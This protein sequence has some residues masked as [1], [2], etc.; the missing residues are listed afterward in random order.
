MTAYVLCFAALLLFA[1]GLVH[2][3]LGEYRL[4]SPL[5]AE[6][7]RAGLL[8]KS[9][10]ARQVLRF[11]WHLTTVGMWGFAALLAAY[12]LLPKD[13]H[14]DAALTIIAIVCALS[15]LMTFAAS[16]GRHL[17]WPVFL[18]IAGLCVVP[19]V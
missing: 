1:T 18:A 5:L 10:F 3:V 15:A 17:A 7:A 9:R 4:I 6:D 13:F 8:A 14:T 2:S 19:L 12:A 11:A 16:R